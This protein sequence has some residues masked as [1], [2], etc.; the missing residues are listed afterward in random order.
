MDVNPDLPSVE[1][2]EA[3]D[4]WGVKVFSLIPTF[5]RR[6]K[7]IAKFGLSGLVAGSA[8]V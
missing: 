6:E 8:F 1:R 2:S 3:S 4:C 7:G 5:T